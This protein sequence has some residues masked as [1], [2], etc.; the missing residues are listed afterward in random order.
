MIKQTTTNLK[1]SRAS[2]TGEVRVNFSQNF[3]IDFETLY[4]GRNLYIGKKILSF[5][6]EGN[7]VEDVIEDIFKHM[8][9]KYLRV[10]FEDGSWLNV[11][12]EHLFYSEGREF[13]EIGKLGE[14]ARV[15]TYNNEAWNWLKIVFIDEIEEPDGISVYNLQTQIMNHYFVEEK[16]VHN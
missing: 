13:V 5:D 7:I 2:F 14:G 4:E 15:L 1:N 12:A 9:D 16:G 3:L 11:T 6:A 10:D 8:V